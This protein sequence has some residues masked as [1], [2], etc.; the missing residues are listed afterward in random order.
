MKDWKELD[1]EAKFKKELRQK[2]SL[3][4]IKVKVKGRGKWE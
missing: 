4:D 3:L 2:L 1:E